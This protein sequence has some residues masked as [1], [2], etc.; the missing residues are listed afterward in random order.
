MTQHQNPKLYAIPLSLF[1]QKFWQ[2]TT[3]GL[4]KFRF[5]PPQLLLFKE[6][7]CSVPF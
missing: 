1:I 2:T 3:R 6:V 5:M 7:C 4:T